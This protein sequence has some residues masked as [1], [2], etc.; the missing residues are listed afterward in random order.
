MWA[1]LGP[2]FEQQLGYRHIVGHDGDVEWGQAFAVR[3]IEIQF[4]CCVLKQ[5]DLYSIQVLLFHSL[6]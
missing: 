1:L 3:C 5:K 4:V 6:K 2:S